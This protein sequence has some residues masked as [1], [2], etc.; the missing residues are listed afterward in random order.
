MEPRLI[1]LQQRAQ[2]EALQKRRAEQTTPEFQSQYAARAGVE[3]THSQGV[4]R[5]D[6]RQAR[7]LGL[8]KTQLQQILTAVALNL[9]RIAEWLAEVPLAK[10]RVSA[11]AALKPAPA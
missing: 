7:Y 10:T 6:L 2:E 8:V 4:R 9:L 1:G 5:C 11:F 3:G